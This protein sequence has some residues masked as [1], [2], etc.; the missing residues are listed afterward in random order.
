MEFALFVEYPIDL[1]TSRS[2]LL[3]VFFCMLAIK[4]IKSRYRVFVLCRNVLSV[5]AFYSFFCQL[6]IK[7]TVLKFLYEII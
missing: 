7:Q 4:G 2:R 5:F 3:I 6:L 1:R